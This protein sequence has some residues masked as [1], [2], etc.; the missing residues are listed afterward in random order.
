MKRIVSPC[1][2]DT[3]EGEARVY[4]EIKFENGNLSIHGVIGP[5]RNGNSMGGGGQCVDKIRNGTPADK[6]NQEMLDKLCDIWDKWHLNDMRPYCKHQ[7]VLGWDLIARK[8]V[9]LY[10]YT[11]CTEA[12]SK[13]KDA[14]RK[15]LEALKK[16][17]TFTP[18]EEQVKYANLSYSITTHKKLTGEM[19]NLYKPRK[20][21]YPGD[22]GETET[23]LLGWLKPEEHPDGILCKP[24]PV[25]GYKYGTSWKKEDIPKAVIEWLLSLPEATR[26][27]AWI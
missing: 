23:K 1:I 18:T 14:E 6:W 13:Q 12:I 25:C 22:K 5:R 3:C 17:E 16:G 10:N 20:P 19:E 27:P 15:A 8:E 9:V 7:K 24:C 11:L 26:K 2:C 4:V 21:M